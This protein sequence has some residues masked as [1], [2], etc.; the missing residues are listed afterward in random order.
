MSLMLCLVG[1]VVYKQA[2]MRINHN[3]VVA[4]Q[5][6]EIWKDDLTEEDHHDEE[7]LQLVDTG[8]SKRRP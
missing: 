8:M 2:P 1:G 3:K 4:E 7:T 5:A 6:D